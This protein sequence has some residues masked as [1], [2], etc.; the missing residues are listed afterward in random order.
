MCQLDTLYY[1]NSFKNRQLALRNSFNCQNYGCS[2]I[3]WCSLYL[4][5]MPYNALCNPVRL[6]CL[7][8]SG[9]L[10]THQNTITTSYSDVWQLPV[11]FQ[12]CQFVVLPGFQH[13]V[14]CTWDGNF[15]N[16]YFAP[17]PRNTID[18]TPLSLNI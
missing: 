5:K 17:H 10:A 18:C 1:F 13:S 16:L 7:A 6:C 11:T 3:Y 9:L 12:A 15:R 4:R 14:S 2:T 8:G